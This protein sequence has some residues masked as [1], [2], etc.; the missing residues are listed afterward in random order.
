MEHLLYARHLSALPTL[1]NSVLL[2]LRFIHMSIEAQLIEITCPRS[3][4]L[5]SS[6]AKIPMCLGWIYNSFSSSLY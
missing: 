4:K 3:K 1:T 6:K 2:K 5:A